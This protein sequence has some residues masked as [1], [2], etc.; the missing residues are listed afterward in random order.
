MAATPVALRMQGTTIWLP[1]LLLL[2]LLEEPVAEALTV[3]A[4]ADVVEA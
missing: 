1:P 2:L 3:D 4:D